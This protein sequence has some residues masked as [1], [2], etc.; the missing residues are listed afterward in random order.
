MPKK[1]NRKGHNLTKE[2][3]ARGGRNGKRGPSIKTQLQNILAGDVPTVVLEVLKNR[4]VTVG[5]KQ[6]PA[7]IKP[8][9]THAARAVALV[10]LK[11][12]L[13]DEAWA[14]K[15]LA[16][17]IDGKPASNDTLTIKALTPAEIAEHDE[18]AKEVFGKYALAPRGQ[19]VE[20]TAEKVNE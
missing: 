4:K 3:M 7:P 12:A 9:D 8:M 15:T 1:G 10:L 17:Y 20:T 2:D 13:A 16:E 18:K 11:N 14:I 6:V 5:D 19:I